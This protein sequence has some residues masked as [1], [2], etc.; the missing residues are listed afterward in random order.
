M[1]KDCSILS[2]SI[3]ETVIILLHFKWNA[4]WVSDGWFLKEA[5]IRRDLGLLETRVAEFNPNSVV[6]GV[7]RYI[8]CVSGMSAGNCGI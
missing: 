4:A 2:I 3:D 7:C 1:E 6:C 8:Y 5:N